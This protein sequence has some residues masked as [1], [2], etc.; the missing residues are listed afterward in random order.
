[1]SPR[2]NSKKLISI[3]EA[4]DFLGISIDTLRRWER[5]GKIRA[6]R[7]LHNNRYFFQKDLDS[8]KNTPHISIQE[9]ASL[10]NLSPTTLRRLDEKGILKAARDKNNVR[11]YTQELLDNFVESTYFAR[12]KS[13]KIQYAASHKAAKADTKSIEIAVLE[14][15]LSTIHKLANFRRFILSTALGFLFFS[16]LAIFLITLFYIQFPTHTASFFGYKKRLPP[17]PLATKNKDVLGSQTSIYFTEEGNPISA[18][19]KPFNAVSLKIV[20]LIR[21]DIYKEVV[22]EEHIANINDV[23]TIDEN[24]NLTPYLPISLKNS[25]QLKL[26]DQDFASNLNAATVLG[27]K[28]GQDSGNLAYFDEAG[29]ISTLRINSFQIADSA[30]TTDK[31]LNLSITSNDIADNAII[32]A[33]IADDSVSL[34]TQTIGSY[35]KSL[36][37]GG[38]LTGSVDAEGSTPTL[39]IGAGYGI[40]VGDDSISVN[41][42][43]SSTTS[44]TSANSGLEVTATGIRLIGGCSDGQILKWDNTNE[45][46]QCQADSGGLTTVSLTTD[47]SGTLPIAN[48]GTNGTATPTAGAVAY[49]TGS[50]YAF[51]LAGSTGQAILSGGTGSPTFTTGTL[52]LAGNF[53]TSGTSALT[54]TTTGSTNVTLP[55]TGTLATLAGTETFT[56]KTLTGPTISSPTISG[57]ITGSGALAW[58][59]ANSSTTSLNIESGLLDL[60]TS[61]TRVGIND[62]SPSN[63]L[64]VGGTAD[65][66]GHVAIGNGATVNGSTSP[67]DVLTGTSAHNTLFIASETATSINSSTTIY[68]G[69]SFNLNLNPSSAPSYVQMYALSAGITINSGNSQNFTNT[70][71]G[72]NGALVHGG[73]GTVSSNYGMGFTT[74]NTSTGTLSDAKGANILLLNAKLDFSGGGTVTSYK[75]LNIQSAINLGTVLNNYGVYIEDQ[76]G[77]GSNNSY[78]LYSAGSSAKNYF[79]GN[80]GIGKDVPGSKLDVYKNSASSDVDIFR[81]LSDVGSTANVKFR[82]DSDGDIFTDG[83]V[84]ISTPADIAEK[85]AN[86]D[87]A[88][89]GDVVVFTGTSSVAKSSSKYQKGIAGVVS[90][91]P[92]ITLAQD[93]GGVPIALAGRVP[94]RVSGQNGPIKKG[95]YLT[96][97]DT[98]GV[99]MRASASGPII[100]TALESFTGDNGTIEI[101]VHTGNFAGSNIS[102]LFPGLEIDLSDNTTSANILLRQISEKKDIFESGVAT[103]SIAASRLIGGIEIITPKLV[104]QSIQAD[105]IEGLSGDD[106]SV[107]LNKDGL[108]TINDESGE[109]V[110]EIDSEG[111]ALFKGALTAQKLKANQIEGLEIYGAKFTELETSLDSIDSR[112]KSIDKNPG[113]SSKESL[114]I[115]KNTFENLF[116]SKQATIEG[117]IAVHGSGIIE[118]VLNVIKSI[119]TNNLIVGGWADF[120]ST[121]F[122]RG[123]TIF[124]GRPTFNKDTAGIAVV[125]KDSDQIDIVF[126]KEY[127]QSPVISATVTQSADGGPVESEILQ[128]TIRYLVV[129]KSTKGFTIKINKNAPDD[130]SFSWIA[131][132]ASDIQPQISTPSSTGDSNNNETTPSE[133]P[134]TI[135]PSATPPPSPTNEPTPSATDAATIN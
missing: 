102:D 18:P 11:V 46:W 131:L 32:A 132:A 82:I 22:P 92:G 121:V 85:Y 41:A 27:R 98:P 130:I 53:A 107:R 62:D 63:T 2:S 99:A 128:G 19:L 105:T 114:T 26:Q 104:A 74:L 87:G 88:E 76:S 134:S 23:F 37:A 116:V 110:V 36:T 58:N 83:G 117:D 10:L 12:Q 95:D 48:G 70:L 68:E 109:S 45:K 59:I 122:F 96:S 13:A 113:S 75:G 43:T 108:F 50:A 120:L 97:S 30:I 127:A 73:T 54:L 20:Q 24:G 40:S 35:I 28:P 89:A 55:T 6:K 34:S 38:G 25:A 129:K 57:T 111:N 125:K 44:T 29:V 42:S 49:G 64:T 124:I 56:N 91:D 78:N 84:T 14:H 65:I 5:Q 4:S 9:A 133:A 17:P 93:T 47:V 101:F 115:D 60:D 15:E 51:S 135:T 119:T 39:A 33:K 80:V 77:T 67:T 61:N 8:L 94:V 21:P 123:D 118:G 3:S 106:I 16:V 100:G 90:T 72:L 81:L 31:I 112:L 7:D 126:E 52:T 103:E 66:Q 71:A 1:M 69:G 79:E 86:S